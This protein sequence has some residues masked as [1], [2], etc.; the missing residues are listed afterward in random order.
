METKKSV[1]P[2]ERISKTERLGE[3]EREREREGGREGGRRQWGCLDVD[4]LLQFDGVVTR[5]LIQL[6]SISSAGSTASS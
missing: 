2:E 5:P 3:R 6:L 4:Q 1:T